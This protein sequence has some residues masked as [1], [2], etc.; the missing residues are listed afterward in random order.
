[1]IFKQKKPKR[2]K[3]VN[4]EKSMIYKLCCKN[5]YITDIYI[6]STTNF[7]Q[8]KTKHKSR[9]NNL[10]DPSYNLNLYKFI[11]DNGNWKNWNMV[12]VDEVKCKSKLELH[13][14]EREWIEK[15]KPTLNYCIPTRTHK[16]HYKDN[17]KKIL[18]EKKIYYQKNKEKIK[19]QKK[20]YREK[21]K[22]KIKEYGKEI[23]NCPHCNKEITKRCLT[24]HI[25]KSC[26]E[27]K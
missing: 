11:R 24:R 21:N 25:K 16:E 18:E 14:I 6:G 7:R 5:P 13:K 27:I 10:K 19:E 2:N 9:C 15:L 3:M 8:R 17:V 4:Y 22:E 26:K 12:L 23:V 1:M 20:E